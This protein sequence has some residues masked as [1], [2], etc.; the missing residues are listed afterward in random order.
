M[1]DVAAE[2]YGR[3]MGQ[4]SEP[5]ADHLVSLVAPEPG[6]RVLDVGCGPGA[7]TGR[8]V[9]RLGPEAVAAVDPSAPFV[10]ATRA[11]FPGADV[12]EA[13]AE[14]LPYDD[15]TFDLCLAQ[16]VVHFMADPVAG[17]REMAR[18][19]RPGGLV[20]ASV[21]DHGG[22]RGPLSPF[23]SAVRSLR[24]GESG[25]SSLPGSREHDLT[26]LFAEAGLT[27]VTETEQGVTLGFPSF[28]AWWEPYTLGVGP[29]GA[30]VGRMAPKDRDVVRERCR[31]RLPAP[32]FE[33][34]SWAWT[35]T[36]RV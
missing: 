35:A 3:F 11:R 21:W 22:G 6:Q 26:R 31:E 32:P 18:V 19:T 36:A 29:A 10:A 4:W 34:S 1:F 27:G 7:L 15:D 9:E 16:L 5:L 24:P 23:W 28:E 20:A 12:R 2:S 14:S 8:L 17:L 25:E 33:L 13:A 30:Y